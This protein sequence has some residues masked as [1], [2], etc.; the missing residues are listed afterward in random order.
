MVRTMYFLIASVAV[1]LLSSNVTAASVGDDWHAILDSYGWYGG[2]FLILAETLLI[3]RLLWERRRRRAIDET[4][5]IASMVRDMTERGRS[6]DALVSLSGRLI[7]AQDEERK[8]IAREIHDDYNQRL[9]LMA[10]DLEE[11]GERVGDPTVDHRRRLAELWNRVSELG[12]DLHSLSHRLH[13]ST[14]ESLGLA[15]ATEALCEEFSEQQGIRIEF[16][17]E[18]VP[19]H[20]EDDVA[21]S[22]FR[23]VQEGLRNIKRHSGADRAEIHLQC[24]DNQLV[25]SIVDRGK[26][27]NSGEPPSREGI[28]IRSMQERL[29]LIGGQLELHSRP[30]EG[31]CIT[32]TVRLQE[33]GRYAA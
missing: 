14:L 27:F 26:G 8:R 32:A 2:I 11:L 25:L 1:I 6:E 3:L 16:T 33:V 20:I 23:I 24:L 21:L 4:K 19:R 13:S 15:A 7:E 17:H 18:N 22:F 29:R 10:I 31:T 30:T 5:F 12:A 28:G 9:A